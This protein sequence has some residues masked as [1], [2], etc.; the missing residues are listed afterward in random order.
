MKKELSELEKKHLLKK[1]HHKKID[2]ALAKAFVNDSDVYK[3]VKDFFAEYLGLDYEFT[4]EELNTELNKRFIDEALKKEIGFFL[5]ALSHMQFNTD[6]KPSQDQLR[7]MISQFKDVIEKL[8]V[9]EEQKKSSPFAWLRNL[10]RRKVTEIKHEPIKEEVPTEEEPE[11]KKDAELEGALKE[12]ESSLQPAKAETTAPATPVALMQEMDK[13]LASRNIP[14]A[15]ESYKKLLQM[16]NK[17]PDAE[18][19]KYFSQISKYYNKLS[20]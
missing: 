1:H 19:Q 8:I 11:R 13:L 5:A 4:H 20:R 15:K 7:K 10:F 9:F 18:K 3:L 17:L 14:A 12:L 2:Y 16:Y 6:T